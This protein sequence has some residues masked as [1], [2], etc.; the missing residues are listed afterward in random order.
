MLKNNIS[1]IFFPKFKSINNFTF[2]LLKQVHV[3]TK[4]TKCLK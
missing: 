1:K 2:E 3:Y 4:N